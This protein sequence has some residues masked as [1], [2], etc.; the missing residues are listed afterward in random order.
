MPDII[1]HKNQKRCFVCDESVRDDEFE[2][3]KKAHMPVC[4]KCIGTDNELKKTKELLDELADGFV[5]G[6]I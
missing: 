5:C 3:H 6:C 2:F 4:L 1:K